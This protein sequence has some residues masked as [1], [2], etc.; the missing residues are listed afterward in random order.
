MPWPVLSTTTIAANKIHSSIRR[1]ESGLLMHTAQHSTGQVCTDIRIVNEEATTCGEARSVCAPGD[2]AAADAGE[3]SCVWVRSPGL[4]SCRQWGLQSQQVAALMCLG[5]KC[6]AIH[7]AVRPT[8]S[9]IRNELENI[10]L[11]QV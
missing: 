3:K 7:P 9:V 2:P 11:N 5:H 10:A 8:A 6:T 4:L 1:P